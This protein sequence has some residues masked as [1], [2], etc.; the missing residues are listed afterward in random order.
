MNEENDFSESSVV[1]DSSNIH[2]QRSSIR[3]VE[4]HGGVQWELECIR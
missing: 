1:P 2:D 4:R 3:L